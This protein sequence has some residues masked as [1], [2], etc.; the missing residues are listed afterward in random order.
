M[1]TRNI[2]I[3]HPY[4]PQAIDLSHD[5]TVQVT[6]PIKGGKPHG[7]CHVIFDNYGQKNGQEFEA[8]CNFN[9][10]QISDGPATF[11]LRDNKLK[12]YSLMQEGRP[13]PGAVVTTY[14]PYIE[15]SL[16]L[17]VE[18]TMQKS[19]EEGLSQLAEAVKQ[20]GKG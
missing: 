3:V 13:A 11:F 8:Y 18:P 16:D 6:G 9:N 2:E 4:A 5:I 15:E 20:S 1:E 10:G 14:A 17:V 19:V 7:L 12:R